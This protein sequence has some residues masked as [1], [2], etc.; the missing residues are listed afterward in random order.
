MK[1]VTAFNRSDFRKWLEKN[2]DKES[3]VSVI[4]YKKHT[5]KTAP[6]HR[7]MVEE[8]ICFGWI[9][10]T[11]KR[12]DEDRYMRH[13]IRRNKNS[14]WS[15]NTLRYAKEMIKK[16]KMTP[17]GLKFFNEGLKKIPHDAGLPK[18]PKMPIQ[19]NNALDKDKKAKEN[20]KK[21]PASTKKMLYRWIL[22]AKRDET[23]TRRSERVV[24]VSRAG[25]KS[26]L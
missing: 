4:L 1:R 7:D 10:T 14:T 6:S 5:G 15:K 13:F 21:L 26:I 9:D 20:F 17:A 22:R 23:R 19:L 2:H 18:N 8:A 3:K 12:L 16:K 11:V 25:K 24:E